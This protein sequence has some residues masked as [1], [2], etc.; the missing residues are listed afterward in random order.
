MVVSHAF[1]LSKHFIHPAERLLVPAFQPCSEGK[2]D[3]RTDHLLVGRIQI[4]LRELRSAA[5]MV[6][7]RSPQPRYTAACVLILLIPSA[8]SGRGRGTSWSLEST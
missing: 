8:M 6:Y 4:P 3:R 2:Q 1:Q 5:S 7:P